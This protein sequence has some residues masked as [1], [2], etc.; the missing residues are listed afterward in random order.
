[1]NAGFTSEYFYPTR[2]VRQGCCSSP[3]LFTLAVELLAIMVRKT[4]EIRGVQT[5]D[6][7]AKISQYVT[8]DVTFF[9]RDS[10]SLE[11]LLHLLNTFALWSGLQINKHKS[12]L[13]LLGNHLHPPT[14]IGGISVKDQVKIL[15]ITFK[16]HMQ[17]DEQYWLN[18]APKI[19]KIK[20][21]C[22]TW[23]N[24]SL[25]LKGKITLVNALMLSVLQYPCSCTFVPKRVPIEIKK[26]ITELIWNSKRPKIAYNVL[27][28]DIEQGG[29]KL[30][31]IE[32]RISS[33][34]LAMIKTLC[35]S[36]NS[37]WASI[38]AATLG[39]K[40]LRLT[41]L[42]RSSLTKRIPAQ[43]S[44]LKQCLETWAKVRRTEPLTE[45]EVLREIIWD[46][47]SINIRKKTYSLEN[48]DHGRSLLHQ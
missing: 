34:H 36:P 15:G 31:D 24:R 20:Q 1:M 42:A 3:S 12:H 45:E 5:G 29:L 18:F 19:S 14:S 47:D 7:C 40:D 11:R 43:F 8:Y 6:K 23:I 21:I 46:N 38:L 4:P 10:A 17:E 27:I 33:C 22:N 26:I 32:A 35:N 9:I 25:S 48:M 13:L 39:T 44:T 30:A 41:L 37:V 16:A 28:Q 2:G